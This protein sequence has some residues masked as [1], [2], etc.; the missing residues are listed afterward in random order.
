M[1]MSVTDTTFAKARGKTISPCSKDSGNTPLSLIQ[2]S[3]RRGKTVANN[4]MF[5]EILT[6]INF[7]KL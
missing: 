4:L 7:R 6:V 3:R 5:S 2:G 1:E